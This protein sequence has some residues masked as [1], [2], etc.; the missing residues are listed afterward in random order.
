MSSVAFQD[1]CSVLGL[2]P[3][4]FTSKGRNQDILESAVIGASA[5]SGTLRDFN[6][7]SIVYIYIHI[8]V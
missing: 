7:I 4:T 3:K 6:C 1:F 2:S 8:Y 5:G